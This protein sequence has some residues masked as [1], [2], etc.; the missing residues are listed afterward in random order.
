M[1]KTTDEK[2]L[3][4]LADLTQQHRDLDSEIQSLMKNAYSDQLQLTRL[5]KRKLHIK[6][7]IAK[8]K[9]A[10]IPDMPA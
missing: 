2:L 7:Q 3:E 6:E 4:E 10:L 9:S 1:P 8:L 5:K